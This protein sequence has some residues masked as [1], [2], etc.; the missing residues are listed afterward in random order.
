MALFV[1]KGYA[2]ANGKRVH[3]HNDSYGPVVYRFIAGG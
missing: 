3:L 1:F 2:V